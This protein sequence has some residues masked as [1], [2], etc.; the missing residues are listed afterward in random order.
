MEG[1]RPYFRYAAKGGMRGKDESMVVRREDDGRVVLEYS[2]MP[3]FDMPVRSGK[4]EIAPDVVDSLI[5]VCREYES[6]PPDAP[7]EDYII[8]DAPTEYAQYDIDG[9]EVR[10]SCMGPFGKAGFLVSGF[11]RMMSARM[12]KDRRRRTGRKGRPGIASAGRLDPRGTCSDSSPGTS[13]SS[14]RAGP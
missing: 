8:H 6:L 12:P 14:S 7:E 9:R 13:G 4:V 1:S 3:S 5:S 11:R 2:I 10:A